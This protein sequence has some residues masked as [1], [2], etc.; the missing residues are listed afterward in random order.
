[1]SGFAGLAI[2]EFKSLLYHGL[3]SSS[4]EYVDVFIENMLYQSSI[5]H[6]E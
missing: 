5:L 6:T 4:Q 3:R 2:P 1:M